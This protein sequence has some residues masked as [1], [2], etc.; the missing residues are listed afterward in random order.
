[1]EQLEEREGGPLR[2]ALRSG[3]VLAGSIAKVDRASTHLDALQQALSPFLHSEPKPYRFVAEVDENT[4]RYLMRLRIE[5]EI[6]LELSLIVG[7]IVQNLRTALDHL[8]WELVRANGQKPTRENAFPIF[9]RPPP[10]EDEHPEQQRWNRNLAGLHPDAVQ[11]IERCQ[12]YHGPSLRTLAALRRLSNE[13]KHRV[14]VS[15]WTAIHDAGSFEI[16][17]LRARDVGSIEAGR[18]YAGRQLNHGDLVL[19]APVQITGPNPD[20]RPNGEL[21]LD[22]GFGVKPVFL[23]DLI[24]M[25]DGVG[26][27]VEAA[28]DLVNSSHPPA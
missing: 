11:L 27:L 16:D 20:V 26:T 15:G 17:V 5:R 9:D 25:R 7:D 8:V 24:G 14:L 23:E 10:G 22:I 19:E 28:G 13:D 3:I 4:S 18:I 12:P 2:L 6:P 21:P 1:M